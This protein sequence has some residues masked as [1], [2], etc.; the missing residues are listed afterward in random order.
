[1]KRFQELLL[2]LSHLINIKAYKKRK[3]IHDEKYYLFFE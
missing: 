3:K 2:D 1:M